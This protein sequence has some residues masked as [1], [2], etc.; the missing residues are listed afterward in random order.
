MGKY[1]NIRFCWAMRL[2]VYIV[3]DSETVQVTK[4]T[5][6]AKAETQQDV[7]NKLKGTDSKI[8]GDIKSIT[9]CTR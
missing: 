2:P 1:F 6:L 3:Y 8:I 7:L 9:E 4:Y 5:H